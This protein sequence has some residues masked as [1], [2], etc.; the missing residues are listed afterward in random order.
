MWLTPAYEP[1]QVSPRNRLLLVLHRV[2]VEVQWWSVELRRLHGCAN[3]AVQQLPAYKV[4][5]VG[6]N[7]SV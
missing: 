2:A 3:R 4:V 1:T 5:R 6:H 7:H